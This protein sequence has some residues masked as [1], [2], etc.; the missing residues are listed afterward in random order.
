MIASRR[1]PAWWRR[2]C[3]RSRRRHDRLVAGRPLR[4]WPH[5]KRV[6]PQRGS[7]AR[8]SA[9]AWCSPPRRPARDA[10]RHIDNRRTEFVRAGDGPNQA[11]RDARSFARRCCSRPERLGE[12]PSPDA[13]TSS[14]IVATGRI[15]ASVLGIKRR[16]V[17]SG[18]STRARARAEVD[19]R[20][21]VESRV[22][23]QTLG[24]THAPDRRFPSARA[25][26]RSFSASADIWTGVPHSGSSRARIART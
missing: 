25:S 15:Q 4:G 18:P 3:K 7:A 17:R 11:E 20:E 21:R 1:A 10:M 5:R 14:E 16:G 23:V 22:E 6:G 9:R 8:Q 26:E 24:L 2:R 12:N 19:A 13:A